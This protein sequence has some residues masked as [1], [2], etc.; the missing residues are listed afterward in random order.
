MA[1]IE[2]QGLNIEFPLYHVASRSLK[3]RLLAK[4]AVRVSTDESNR[5]VV[6][7]LR[8]LTFTIRPGER[9]ALVGHN[10]AGKTTLLRTLAG[11]YEPVG[12]SLRVEGEIGSLI[13]PA[14]GT[15]LR[16]LRDRVEALGGVLF[17]VS[18]PGG[19]TRISVEVPCGS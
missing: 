16:G 4:A 14:A 17:V 8:D 2:A 6:N 18:P 15:G 1:I 19:P 12:G 11:I 9:V 13:D 5:V 3:K 10:G 7:A